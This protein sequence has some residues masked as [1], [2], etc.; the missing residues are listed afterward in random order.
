MSL[1]KSASFPVLDST[2]ASEPTNQTLL[3]LGH[4]LLHHAHIVATSPDA[5]AHS[6]TLIM[7]RTQSAALVH[8]LE[9]FDWLGASEEETS[10]Y[11]HQVLSLLI[12]SQGDSLPTV[13]PLICHHLKP[14]S[15]KKSKAT[16][17][18]VLG[19]CMHTISLAMLYSC[20]FIECCVMSAGPYSFNGRNEVRQR[21]R[22]LI[23]DSGAP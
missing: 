1:R 17:S 21:L 6:D 14:S 2:A 8:Y 22:Q 12:T 4:Q 11:K 7:G 9:D 5:H 10:T 23:R 16:G 19:T 15:R 20:P 3:V 18:L 13:L